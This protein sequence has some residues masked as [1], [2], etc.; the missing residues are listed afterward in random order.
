[1]NHHYQIIFQLLIFVHHLLGH[2]KYLVILYIIN[3]Y[4]ELDINHGDQLK[5]ELMKKLFVIIIIQIMN[6]LKDQEIFNMLIII[7]KD[8][9]L[10]MIIHFIHQYHLFLNN[11]NNNHNNNHNNIILKV[12]IYYFRIFI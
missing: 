5:L 8:K 12:F 9:K 4:R 11:I 1:M 6:H 10:L 3:Y 7:I 2:L